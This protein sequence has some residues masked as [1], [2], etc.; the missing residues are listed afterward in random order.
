VGKDSRVFDVGYGM[1]LIACSFAT[2]DDGV[3]TYIFNEKQKCIDKHNGVVLW[4]IPVV[5]S[6]TVGSYYMSPEEL[7]E[8]KNLE[9]VQAAMT[10][11][12]DE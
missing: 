5:T 3:V 8:F 10:W 4:G 12:D 7:E 11:F 9:I 6:K 1:K 2:K